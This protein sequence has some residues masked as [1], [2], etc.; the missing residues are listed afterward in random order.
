MTLHW[1]VDVEWRV[2][3]DAD[4][5]FASGGDVNMRL[6]LPDPETS[7]DE[8]AELFVR[9]GRREVSVPAFQPFDVA[10]PAVLVHT[11]W[12]GHGHRPEYRLNASPAFVGLGIFPVRAFALRPDEERQPAGSVSSSEGIP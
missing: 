4:V 6:D 5:T 2:L 1:E 10:D 7:Q 3:L 8:V 9:T 11:G 12:D